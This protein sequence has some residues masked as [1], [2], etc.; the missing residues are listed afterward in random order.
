MHN[1]KIQMGENYCIVSSFTDD[2]TELVNSIQTLLDEGWSLM[3][4]L[5]ASN[6]MLFQALNK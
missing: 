2:I 4:G 6:S 3:G 1:V 5:T